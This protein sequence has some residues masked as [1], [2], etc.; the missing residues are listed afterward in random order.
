MPI[1]SLSR[2]VLFAALPVSFALV[3]CSSEGVDNTAGH[4]TLTQS[5]F[6]LASI[7]ECSQDVVK[8]DGETIRKSLKL[9]AEVRQ[10]GGQKTPVGVSGS[11]SEVLVQSGET[12]RIVSFGG[13]NGDEEVFKVLSA[14]A[15]TID[16]SVT[17][18][19][20]IQDDGQKEEA[21]LS[22][23]VISPKEKAVAVQLKDDAADSLPLE[24]TCDQNL[25]NLWLFSQEHVLLLGSES[26]PE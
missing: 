11:Y 24:I 7:A 4:E 22:N 10:N 14:T 13:G 20:L 2:S 5:V 3:G 1:R 9:S 25:K 12:T 21:L 18:K 16:I 23:L 19:A 17:G 26:L 15:E 8:K 6:S